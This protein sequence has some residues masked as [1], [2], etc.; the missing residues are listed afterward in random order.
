MPGSRST[1]VAYLL[2]IKRTTYRADAELDAY[3]TRIATVADLVIVDGSPPDVF[4][5]HA[6]AWSGLGRHVPVATDL[7]VPNG[8]VAGVLTGLRH[9]RHEAVI[10]ADD[11]VRY[12]ET[13]VAAMARA[14]G[15]AEVVRPQNYYA[16]L[17]WH[18]LWDT[19]RILLNRASSGDWPGT[20]GVRRSTIVATGGYAGDVLFENLELVRTVVAAGGRTVRADDILVRR[21]PAT[22]RHFWSQRVRQAYDE[23]ARPRRL[24]VQLALLPGVLLMLAVPALRL[25]PLALAATTIA[26]AERGRRLRGGRAVFPAAAS[27]F[28]PLWVCERALTAWLA[29]ASRVFRGGMPYAGSILVRAATPMSELRRRYAGLVIVTSMGLN[30]PLLDSSAEHAVTPTTRS[31]SARSTT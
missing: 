6:M 26:I 10:I 31:I 21:I 22:T 28:A 9:V 5:R 3:L 17:P 1:N 25:V 20:L 23:I 27:L 12:D 16:P 29:M 4:A 2:P 24:A 15:S 14:L 18:A 8:K 19:G 30:D 11:D 7:A 13:G